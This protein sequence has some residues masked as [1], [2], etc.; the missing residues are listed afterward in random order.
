MGK[1][2]GNAPVYYIVVQVRFN[3]ILALDPHIP[4]IQED[5][6]KAGY[7][8]FEKRAVVV[9]DLAH[10]GGESSTVQQVSKTNFFFSNMETTRGFVLGQNSLA[11]H[12]TEYDVFET[13][14]AEFLRVLELLHRIVQLSYSERVG[15][16]YLDAVIPARI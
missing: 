14:S 2:M 16:R 8:D 10:G 12:T 1:K 4:T 15:V 13:F 9:F 11:M 7:P 3:P 5:L 6:R